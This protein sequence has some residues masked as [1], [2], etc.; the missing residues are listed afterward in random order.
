MG[1]RSSRTRS[2]SDVSM[3]LRSGGSSESASVVASGA[4][5]KRSS[6]PGRRPLSRRNSSNR[7]CRSAWSRFLRLA[8]RWSKYASQQL[9]A[10]C[11]SVPTPTPR[12]APNRP[13]AASLKRTS[14]SQVFW[15]AAM[16]RS[17]S[18][19]SRSHAGASPNAVSR[20]GLVVSSSGPGPPRDRTSVSRSWPVFSSLASTPSIKARAGPSRASGSRSPAAGGGLS[21]STLDRPRDD[22]TAPSAV[23]SRTQPLTTASTTPSAPRRLPS[24]TRTVAPAETSRGSSGTSVATHRR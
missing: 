23:R 13:T 15:S 6:S 7:S 5:M 24:V 1:S 10:R 2:S 18:S 22:T 11:H 8:A 21:T 20:S 9:S 14:S 4:V 19:T 3:F 12:D 17:R 16:S